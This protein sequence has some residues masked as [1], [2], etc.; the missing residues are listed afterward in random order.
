MRSVATMALLLCGGGLLGWV[1]QALGW[2]RAVGLSGAPP[3]AALPA[4]VLSGPYRHVRHPRTLGVLCLLVAGALRGGAGMCGLAAGA[5][6]LLVWSA[7][8][9]DARL[10]DRFGAAYARYRRAVPLLVPRLR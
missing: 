10:A 5:A 1:V 6:L 4:L 8:R 3:H 2:R 7:R 9:D